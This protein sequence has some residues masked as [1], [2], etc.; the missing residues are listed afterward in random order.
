MTATKG[1]M[2][3]LT[4]V[5]PFD[6]RWFKHT[7]ELFPPWVTEFREHQVKAAEEVVAAFDSGARVVWLDAPVGSGK[8]LI[9]DMVRRRMVT[10]ALYVCSTKSL[11]QQVLDD[12]GYARVLKGRANYGTQRAPFPTI[13]CADCDMTGSVVEGTASCSWCEEP[14][15]CEYKVAKAQA[16]GAEL[17]VLNT[18]YFLNE[19]N[20]MGGFSKQALTIIDESDLIEREL[21]GFVSLE[22]GRALLRSLRVTVPKKGSHMETIRVWLDQIVK[23]AAQTR[24]RG[25][26]GGIDDTRERIRLGRLVQQ[27]GQVMARE[28]GWVRQNDSEE[29]LVL[30]PV[31]V[32]NDARRILWQH[33]DRWLLMSG[34]TISARM[35]AEALGVE[36]LEDREDIEWAEVKV[37]MTF[38]VENR[39]VYYCPI[40]HNVRAE[41][42]NG[43]REEIARAAR[44]VVAKYP[45]DKVLIHTHSY[46]MTRIVVTELGPNTI[47]YTNARDRDAALEKFKAAEGG[48][49][50]V[51][52]S[53]DRGVDLADDLARCIIIT[54]IPYPNLGDRQVSERSHAKDGRLWYLVQTLRGLVQMTGRGMRSETDHADS[55]IL[56]ARFGKVWGRGKR[57]LPAW[58]V[59]AV[60]TVSKRSLSS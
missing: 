51:A 9:A 55:W 48:A 26:G 15:E 1:R 13:T 27:I 54:K 35:E 18:A 17:A 32:R 38:P 53:M 45:D 23:P 57:L 8:T 14:R 60:E 30:K 33:S 40:A 31:D 10:R 41:Q 50:L 36:G 22:L 58:W 42:G 21:M 7:T 39:P 59:E 19:A 49:V 25:L 43:A 2:S 46:E 47:T 52:P 56:D 34:T 16:L 28:D 29:S 12:F 24:S 20:W 4:R 5:T 37:P 44:Q 3:D 6:T 11:Q